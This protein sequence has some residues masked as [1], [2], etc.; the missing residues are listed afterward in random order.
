MDWCW[1]TRY[2][3]SKPP[4]E[5]QLVQ[6]RRVAKPIFIFRDALSSFLGKK[7]MVESVALTG[8]SH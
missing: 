1:W 7:G 2:F 3:L 5:A 8:C 6:R 4:L